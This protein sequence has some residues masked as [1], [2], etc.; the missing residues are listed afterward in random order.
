MV[1][2]IG[3]VCRSLNK[4]VIFLRQK[5]VTAEL[6]YRETILY[7]NGDDFVIFAVFDDEKGSLSE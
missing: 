4:I 5:Y 3:S 2:L 7:E 6:Q 1:I